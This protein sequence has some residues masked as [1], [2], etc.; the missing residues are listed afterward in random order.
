[1]LASST[2]NSVRLIATI[3][4]PWIAYRDGWHACS[5]QSRANFF[6][7]TQKMYMYMIPLH[8][9]WHLHTANST[10][11]F[12][13]NLYGMSIHDMYAVAVNYCNI[14]VLIRLGLALFLF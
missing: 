6:K 7:Q 13:W 11:L 8:A 14:E 2:G 3:G 5:S 9:I 4:N 12:V 1:M 10:I